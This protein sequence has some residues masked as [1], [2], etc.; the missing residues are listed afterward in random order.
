MAIGVSFGGMEKPKPELSKDTFFSAPASMRRARK[1]APEHALRNASCS[2][3]GRGAVTST[4]PAA[5]PGERWRAGEAR[6]AAAAD[7]GGDDHA[8]V[9]VGALAGVGERAVGG[10]HPDEVVG[11]GVRGHVRVDGARQAA[12]RGLDLLV[13]G[14]RLEAED[15]VEARGV[16]R[17]GDGCSRGG[18][19]EGCGAGEGGR[20]REERRCLGEWRRWR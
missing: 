13:A 20:G 16:V 4:G 17:S 12:V 19:G 2:G 5:E 10:L 14:A 7:G 18:A 11:G 6:R 1:N 3:Q 9:V 15:V 8:A